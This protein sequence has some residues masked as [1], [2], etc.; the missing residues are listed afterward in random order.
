[1]SKGILSAGTYMS[2]AVESVAG[3]RPESGYTKI[4]LVKNVPNFNEK[5]ETKQSTTFDDL[6][7]HTSIAGLKKLD[8]FDIKG[9]ATDE[10]ENQWDELCALYDSAERDG[11][12][13][14]FCVGHPAREKATYFTGR[15]LS[16]A[17]DGHSVDELMEATLYIEAHTGAFRAA[18]PTA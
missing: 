17:E 9:N 10:L 18:A 6:K 15:P 8:V 3:T 5:P 12:S 2:Y 13:V 4:M 11:L 1:M 16:Y 7:Y 14:W